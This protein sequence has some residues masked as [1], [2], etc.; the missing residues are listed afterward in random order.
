MT[1]TRPPVISTILPFMY[2]LSSLP[3]VSIPS[4]HLHSFHHKPEQKGHN[5]S[6]LARSPHPTHS[7]LLL[8]LSNS[9]RTS[10]HARV[11][12]RVDIP[13]LAH[14]P[15]VSTNPPAHIRNFPESQGGPYSQPPR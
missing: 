10:D 5:I 13:R 11:G 12:G 14:T 8:L 9:R 7:D 2:R 4:N 6:N 15:L 3:L 1:H